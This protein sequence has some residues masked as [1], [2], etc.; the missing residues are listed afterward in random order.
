MSRNGLPGGAVL[1]P[2]SD[3]NFRALSEDDRELDERLLAIEK[4]GLP[5][6]GKAGGVL[7]GEYPNPEFAKEPAYKAEI[8]NEEAARKEADSTEKAAREAADKA[9]KEARESADSTEKTAR[10]SADTTLKGEVKTEKEAREAAD[11]E[12]VKGPASSTEADIATY[13]GTTGKIIKDSGKTIASVLLEAEEVARA[14]ASA[15]AAGLSVK[16]PVA[17]ASTAALTVTKA[18]A[19][20]LEGK[21]PLEVDGEAG[22][23]EGTRLLVKNQVSELQNGIYEVTEDKSFGGSGKF[24]EGGGKWAEGETWLLTRSAD[25]DTEAEVKQG[26]FVL[27]TS[28]TTNAATT[29]ILTTENPIVIGTTAQTFAA[30]TAKP[31]GAAGGDLEGTYPN[32][33][34]KAKAIVNGDVSDTAGI[35]Y[36]KL[37]LAGKILGSD[38]VAG[39]VEDTDLAS[40]N[41]AIYRLLLSTAAAFGAGTGAATYIQTLGNLTNGVNGT[42]VTAAPYLDPADYAVNGKTT[43]YR[44]RAQVLTNATAPA[45]NFTFGLYPV[46]TVKGAAGGI[47]FNVGTVI[48]GST[49]AINTPAKES[50]NQGNSGDFTAPAANFYVIGCVVSGTTAASSWVNISCQLQYRAT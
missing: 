32:P 18:T 35:E 15:A 48:S 24:G 2:A 16:N 5:P 4:E 7:K 22:F 28:G 8:E 41:N 12:R 36:K 14:L 40:P 43:R 39:T 20:T 46:S 13:N 25:A 9:E 42:A 27:V 33:S 17:Y 34:I 44:L 26:M 1:D 47:T 29:W 19:T 23:A 11:A 21:S 10:E 49:V 30:F 37:S 31:T 50:L 6:S 38:I 45:V 3:Q